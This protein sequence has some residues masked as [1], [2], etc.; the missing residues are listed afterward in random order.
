MTRSARAEER[1]P[2][3]RAAARR[4]PNNRRRTSTEPCVIY[5]GSK[6]SPSRTGP[7]LT[8]KSA[9]TTRNPMTWTFFRNSRWR[10]WPSRSPSSWSPA[11]PRP[12]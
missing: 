6:A 5:Q 10:T 4:S 11:Q 8:P 3:R 12:M 1:R 2:D 9:R 7:P